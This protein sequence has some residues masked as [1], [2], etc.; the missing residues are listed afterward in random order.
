MKILLLTNSPD[1]DSQ[2][3]LIKAAEKRKHQI[4]SFNPVDLCA[5]ISG[6]ISGHDGLFSKDSENQMKRLFSNEFDVI[7]P[8]FSGREVWD[9]GLTILQHLAGNL[10]IPTA[11][12]PFGLR[13]A[14]NK[15][16]SHQAF[17]V[18]KLQT[19]ETLFINKPV[20]FQ[21]ITKKLGLPIVCKTP[22]GSQGSGVFILSDE[23]GV[24]TTL[25]AF[26]RINKNLLLQRFIDTGNPKS[27]LRCFV[28]DSEVVAAYKRFALA[29]DFRSNYS[30]SHQ[31]EKTE[32]TPEEKRM[33]VDAAFSVGLPGVCGVDICR[34]S[35][36]GNKPYLIE[37]NGNASL[38]GVSTISGVDVAGKIIE[39]CEKIARKPGSQ[40][41]AKSEPENQLATFTQSHF[42]P[43]SIN[44]ANH[45]ARRGDTN[46][47]IANLK[48]IGL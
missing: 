32:L 37:A 30:L 28:V 44:Q 48:K 18:A 34:D 29:A 1:S 24:S 26:S 12:D 21:F 2:Q 43:G 6:T 3:R 33:A 5:F 22:M 8:R 7:L 13:V 40:A 10:K 36:D 47:T 17:S 45:L 42:E 27:D 31:G 46:E 25:S 38:T 15:F 19:I 4:E 14:A 35:K 41:K 23:L 20:D 16:L 39:Y 11:S 9:F